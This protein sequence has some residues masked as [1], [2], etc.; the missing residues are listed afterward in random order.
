[1]DEMTTTGPDEGT[2]E[3]WGPRRL[4][5]LEYRGKTYTVDFRLEEMRLVT[6]DYSIEWFPFREM[7]D[8][9]LKRML[10]RLRSEVWHLYYMKGLDD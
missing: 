2:S 9:E 3:G 1:M 6:E 10:R 4:P 7:K 8:E 5:T